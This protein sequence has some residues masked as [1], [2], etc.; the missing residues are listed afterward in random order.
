[1][2][3]H[4]NYDG[5]LLRC[6]EHDDACKL[7]RELHDIPVGGHFAGETMAHKILRVGYYWPTLLRDAHAYARKCKSYQV[8]AGRG[9]REVIPLHLVTISRPFKHWGINAHMGNYS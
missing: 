2:L 1:V 3:F 5:V 4:V 9:K 6:I 7:L 8:S